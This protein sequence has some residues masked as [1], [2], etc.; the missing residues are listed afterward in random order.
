[1]NIKYKW[2]EDVPILADLCHIYDD[3]IDNMNILRELQYITL[4][5]LGKFMGANMGK[6]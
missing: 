1:M 3:D 5:S 6:Y 4:P 2:I